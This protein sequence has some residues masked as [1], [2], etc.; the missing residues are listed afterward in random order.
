[1]RG[2]PPGR[3]RLSEYIDPD[4]ETVTDHETAGELAT[5][6]EV[7][8][9]AAGEPE[10]AWPQLGETWE[11]EGGRRVVVA[12]LRISEARRE[13]WIAGDDGRYFNATGATRVE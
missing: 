1:M 9:E 11:F 6:E 10:Q 12:G 2:R 8:E 7:E 5:E 3:P 4:N 13:V